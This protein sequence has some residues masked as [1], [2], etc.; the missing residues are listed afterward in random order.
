[1]WRLLNHIHELLHTI[2]DNQVETS[3]GVR[4]MAAGVK[5][6]EA[7]VARVEATNADLRGDVTTILKNVSSIQ[8]DLD[9]YIAANPSA[10]PDLQAFVDRL[11]AVA[12]GTVTVDQSVK[13]AAATLAA[14]DAKIFVIASVQVNPATLALAVGNSQSVAAQAMNAGGNPVAGSGT[15]SSSDDTVATVGT[16]GTVTAVAV[17]TA[18]I[19]ATIGSVSGT[20]TV[21]VS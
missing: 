9:A 16:D 18:T 8:T 21:T 13:D 11:N 5:E 17:G 7:S 4:K 6:L 1:M 2:L 14:E 10:G 15:F 3:E 12:D 19:T 20:C